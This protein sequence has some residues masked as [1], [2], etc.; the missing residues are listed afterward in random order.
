MTTLP[1]NKDN[2]T[3]PV[4]SPQGISRVKNIVAIASGK[5]GV[6]KSTI[7]SN[8]AVALAKS[9]AKVGL[10]DADIYGPNAPIMMGVKEE[11][12]APQRGEHGN[13]LEP[14][15]TH[16]VKLVSAGFLVAAGQP[17]MWRGPMLGKLL[18]QFLHQV[19]WGELDYLIVDMPPGT[20]DVQLT[21]AKAVPMAGAVI[22]TTPQDVALADAERGMNMFEKLNVP[23]LGVVE[24]MSYFVP[25]DAPEKKYDIFGSGN[26][27]N[28]ANTL[29]K[30]L[31]GC[32]P[33][34]MNVRLSG[35]NGEPV[36]MAQPQSASA[37]ALTQIAEQIAA[38][39]LN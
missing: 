24:N 23:V 6:G 5:G 31:L 28:A 16:G 37:K 7:A 19:Q 8:I 29:G 18:K 14:I 4:S 2:V 39:V 33:L 21:I 17:I 12:L 34:E 26:G 22:V 20:G 3:G 11:K 15:V 30:P 9:G 27:E 38:K 13:E 32:V 25:P 10:L 1:L 36:V 35:D